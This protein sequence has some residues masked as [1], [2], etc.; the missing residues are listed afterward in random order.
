MEIDV[1]LKDGRTLTAKPGMAEFVAFERHFD[2][3]TSALDDE[4]RVEYLM[5]L[6]HRSL[7]DQVA[8]D[9]DRFL[10]NVET[11]E[12]DEDADPSGDSEG[13]PDA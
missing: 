13:A 1:R 6:V 9:F 4:G 12:V 3:P 10:K 11:I 2:K 8:D 7:G 5:F